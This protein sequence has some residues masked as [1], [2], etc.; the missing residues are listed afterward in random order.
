MKDI[1]RRSA[2]L[3]MTG[4]ATSL[5]YAR[6]KA[7]VFAVIGDRY[8]NSDYI[9]TALNRDIAKELKITI[10][11]TDDYTALTSETLN[12]YRMLIVHR[13][14]MIWPEGYGTVG[15][16][17]EGPEDPEEPQ[18][19]P[20]HRRQRSSANLRCRPHQANRSF[21][22]SRSKGRPSASSSRTAVRRCSCTMSLT[23]GSPILTFAMSWV[24][25]IKGIRPSGNSRS[26]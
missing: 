25:P 21:G 7:T 19:S 13:D 3:T 4:L 26:R 18:K 17:V 16:E 1:T 5:A 23:S 11:L 20:D 15:E 8:H 9:R 24:P 2:I 14:G 10:D 12:G 22:S 6:E